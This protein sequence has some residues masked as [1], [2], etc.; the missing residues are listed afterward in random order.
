MLPQRYA[1]DKLISGTAPLIIE[2]SL[3]PILYDIFLY[4]WLANSH[5]QSTYQTM[6]LTKKLEDPYSSVSPLCPCRMNII[7]FGGVDFTLREDKVFRI[8][9]LIRVRTC[10]RQT[11]LLRCEYK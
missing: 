9:L 8:D 6:K 1:Y 3:P 4:F 7:A 11:V 5:L 2:N 10:A